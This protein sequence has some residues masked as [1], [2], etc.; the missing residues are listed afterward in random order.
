MIQY[1]PCI[2]LVQQLM[3]WQPFVPFNLVILPQ[4]LLIY[5][6]LR[7]VIY[8]SSCA[9]YSPHKSSGD[10]TCFPTSGGWETA[11]RP[12]EILSGCPS[13]VHGYAGISNYTLLDMAVLTHQSRSGVGNLRFYG[14]PPDFWGPRWTFKPIN[15]FHFN[16]QIK[17]KNKEF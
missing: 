14:S 13:R 1:I 9:Y 15:S 16:K 7:V 10:S 4:S 12:H 17:T 3:H 6:K 11:G 8:L 5:F 2:I